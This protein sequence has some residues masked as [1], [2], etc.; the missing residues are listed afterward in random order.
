[1]Q[2]EVCTMGCR[3]IPIERSW[4]YHCVWW[5]SE[6]YA[7]ARRYRSRLEENPHVLN[8]A[9]FP[10]EVHFHWDGYSNKNMTERPIEY[11]VFVDIAIT[12]DV[13]RIVL[14]DDC[15]LSRWDF[16][17]QWVQSAFNT[18]GFRT[19]LPSWRLRWEC[20]MK[21]EFCPVWGR[22]FQCH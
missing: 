6:T 5:D 10:Y 3:C 22:I 16:V 18:D 20:A 19:S 7:F 11:P 15:T 4:V 14:C 1:M 17:A 2:W 8:V 12:S 21:T 13:C 9:C